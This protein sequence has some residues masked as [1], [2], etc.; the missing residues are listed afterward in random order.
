MESEAREIGK[1]NA[2]GLELQEIF[3]TACENISKVLKEVG[4]NVSFN[5]E[6]TAGVCST[7][8]AERLAANPNLERQ[9]FDNRIKVSVTNEDSWLR[10]SFKGRTFLNFGAK[11]CS[12]L[13]REITTSDGE[14]CYYNSEQTRNGFLGYVAANALNLGSCA[15]ATTTAEKERI[16]NVALTQVWNMTKEILTKEQQQAVAQVMMPSRQPA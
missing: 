14:Q 11:T 15:S 12:F 13:F 6:Q 3:R 8:E 10:A 4:A 1:L 2:R 16:I 7:R 5:I 9:I